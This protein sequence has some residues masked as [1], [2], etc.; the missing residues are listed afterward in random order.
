MVAPQN[1]FVWRDDIPAI[2]Q[3]IQEVEPKTSE[4]VYLTIEEVVK[5]VGVS[6]SHAFRQCAT[7]EMAKYNVAS[8]REFD[9]YY[10]SKQRLGRMPKYAFK[11]SDIEKIGTILR[12]SRKPAGRKPISKTA[13]VK[14]KRIEFEQIEKM[15]HKSLLSWQKWPHPL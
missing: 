12:D 15:H 14:H 1:K 6:K 7:H 2:K 11:A 4:V 9:D 13:K 3:R 10:V 5:L 8:T